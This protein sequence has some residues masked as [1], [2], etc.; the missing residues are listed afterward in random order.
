MIL[1]IS[2]KFSNFRKIIN[3][4]CISVIFLYNNLYI[5]ILKKA[6]HCFT[7]SRKK[8]K[9]QELEK[10]DKIHSTEEINGRGKQRNFSLTQYVKS[11]KTD[12]CLL[13]Q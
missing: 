5:Y 11:C 6:L 10:S 12:A 7:K 13:D 4:I 2:Y 8:L 9:V 1:I 3:Y